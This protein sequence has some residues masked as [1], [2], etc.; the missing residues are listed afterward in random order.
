MQP[1]LW[2]ISLAVVQLGCIFG[3]HCTPDHELKFNFIEMRNSAFIF[4]LNFRAV[5]QTTT[6]RAITHKGALRHHHPGIRPD[7]D[8]KDASLTTPARR[9]PNDR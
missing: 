8:A 2:G 7:T 5:F 6:H 3:N 9:I 1:P 4:F